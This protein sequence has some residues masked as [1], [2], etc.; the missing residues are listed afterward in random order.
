MNLNAAAAITPSQPSP[1][2]E[3]RL[4][5]HNAYLMDSGL[6]RNDLGSVVDAEVEFL[7]GVNVD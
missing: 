1:V 3:G 6:R 2:A 4:G 5:R 7:L